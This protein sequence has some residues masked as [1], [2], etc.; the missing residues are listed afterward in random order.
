MLSL[1][2]HV[3]CGPVNPRT[4]VLRGSFLGSWIWG[5][6]VVST[7]LYLLYLAFINS[8]EYS[9]EYGISPGFL[10]LIVLY[11]SFYPGIPGKV[12]HAIV[13]LIAQDF[14]SSHLHEWRNGC[15]G[16]SMNLRECAMIDSSF[17]SR[18][19]DFQER[20]ISPDI[21]HD[22]SRS[23][24]ARHSLPHCFSA[25]DYIIPESV[26]ISHEKCDEGERTCC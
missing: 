16:D 17:Q 1:P 12:H 14:R 19:P 25:N 7:W 15:A 4:V 3:S 13:S 22:G 23:N 6:V 10:L 21:V 20:E 9:V 8:P 11:I 24:N 26:S 2:C 18:Y 5:G